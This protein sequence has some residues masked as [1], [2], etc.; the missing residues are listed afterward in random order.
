MAR[1]LIRAFQAAPDATPQYREALDAWQRGWSLFPVELEDKTPIAALLPRK[2]DGSAGWSPLQ[3]RQPTVFE[4][5]TWADAEAFGVVTGGLTG[6][7]V[8]DVDPGGSETLRGKHI[9]ETIVS[10]TI[11]GRHY[12]FKHPPGMRVKTVKGFLPGLDMRG[13]GGYAVLPGP[14]GREWIIS[15]DEVEPAPLPD[16]LFPLVVQLPEKQKR[17]KK[18]VPAVKPSNPGSRP[19]ALPG[20]N[21][22]NQLTR[23]FQDADAVLTMCRHMGIAVDTVPARCHDVLPGGEPDTRPSAS[24]YRND[25]GNFVYRSFRLSTESEH[26]QFF[27]LQDVYASLV[28]GRVQ[29]NERPGGKASPSVA[30]WALRLLVDAGVIAPAK[31]RH[32]RLSQDAPEAA[33]TA[34]HGFLKLLG[35]KWLHSAG[36]ASPYTWRF[37]SDWTGLSEW[38]AKAGIYWLLENGYLYTVSKYK[39]TRLY[40]PRGSY[41]ERHSV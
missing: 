28:T 9:P 12:Y 21:H 31:V 13:D 18:P 22:G 15:P 30:T 5:S 10:R 34:Y 27:H 37:C 16:W 17:V 24:V 36:E 20:V 4:M 29:R 39:R 41:D 2:P 33:R 3:Q 14:E 25:S 38:D 32:R 35:C 7:V 1:P 23:W 40:L 26:E 11:R 19:A 6:L 8:L